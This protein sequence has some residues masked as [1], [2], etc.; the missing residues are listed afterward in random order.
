MGVQEH[1]T[2]VVQSTLNPKWNAS[3]QFTL[4]DLHE[5]VLCI[6]V[7]DRD[8]FSP[9]DFLGRTEVRIHDILKERSATKGPITK[10]LLL[11]EV[12]SGE[13]VVKLDL[14]LFGTL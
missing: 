8:L 5:D 14:Q 9:N 10:R 1:K 12:E 13:V 3:M 4:K 2:K 7:Y 6:T 11:H